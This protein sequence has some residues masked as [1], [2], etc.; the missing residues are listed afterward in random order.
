LKPLSSPI[1]SKERHGSTC[2]GNLSFKPI[3]SM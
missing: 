2:Q 3:M 1:E